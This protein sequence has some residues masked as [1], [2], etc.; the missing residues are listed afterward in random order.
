MANK[1]EVASHLTD[2]EHSIL[3]NVYHK[4]MKAMGGGRKKTI[5]FRQYQESKGKCPGAMF[6]SLF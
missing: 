2:D 3:L 1:L 4:H 5:C 6:G